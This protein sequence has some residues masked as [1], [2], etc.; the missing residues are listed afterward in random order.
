MKKAV[1]SRAPI[2]P[3]PEGVEGREGLNPRDALDILEVRARESEDYIIR[4]ADVGS[5]VFEYLAEYGAPATRQAVAANPATP[6]RINRLL[7]DDGTEDVRA[8]LAAKIA[9][10]MPGLEARETEE[11][12]V[13]TL[14]TLEVLARD[15]A[16][17]V[18]AILA[19]EIKLLDCVPRDVALRLAHDV[20]VLVAAPIL[21]YSPLLSQADLMEIIAGGQVQQVLAAVARRRPLGEDVSEALVQ[22]LDVSAI[23]ALLVN[24]D[25]KMRKETL[26]RVVEEAEAIESWH[27]PLVLRADL[28][29][30][31]IRRI[32]GFVGASLLEQLVARG[33]LSD[34]TRAH[35]NRRLRGRLE[36]DNDTESGTASSEQIVSAAKA[37]GTLDDGFVENAASSG[38]RETVTLA[39]AALAQVPEATVRKILSQRG[40]KPLVALVWRA[41]LSMRTAFKIQ[42]S[43]MKLT[44]RELLPARGGINF[45]LSKEE[46]RW[47]LAYFDIPI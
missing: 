36:Q 37:R 40:A 19:E 6:A 27:L 16:V 4:N 5:A 2:T 13:L 20:E 33:D 12:V 18:R 9:R 3:I 31:A 24:P 8:E 41:H 35:L 39:L 7:A 30:R 22:S 11:T 47:H 44:G 38:S 32:G 15:S 23:A 28:S 17:R 25:A 29:A 34:A 10:L 26:D 42:T 1:S 21:E 14:D 45:P 46:M 43:V